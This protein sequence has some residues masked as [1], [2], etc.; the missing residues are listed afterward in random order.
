MH[1]K[2]RELVKTMEPMLLEELKQ[3]VV[4]E[5]EK[6]Q[7]GQSGVQIEQIHSQMSAED[8]I[9]AMQEIARVLR[10]DNTNSQ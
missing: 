3:V 1:L 10:G 7:Q 5:I 6:R 8:K 4:T 2:F 9:Q